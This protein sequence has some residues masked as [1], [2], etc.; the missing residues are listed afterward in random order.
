M[1]LRVTLDDMAMM[2]ESQ[3]KAVW[4]LVDTRKIWGLTAY[5]DQFARLQLRLN[6]Y[7]CQYPHYCGALWSN[8]H[9]HEQLLLSLVVVLQCT[10]PKSQDHCSRDSTWR[11]KIPSELR[12]KSLEL[13]DILPAGTATEKNLSSFGTIP[14]TS[15]ILDMNRFDDVERMFQSFIWRG[16]SFI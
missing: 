6:P 2:L 10:K 9:P 8:T 12:Y 13:W 3:N 1:T 14:S 16:V 15:L 11:K 4:S 7:G 5:G